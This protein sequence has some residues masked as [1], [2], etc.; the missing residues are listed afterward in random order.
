MHFPKLLVVTEFPPNSPTLMVQCLRGFPPSHIHW[1]SYIPESTR[2]YGQGYA[3]HYRCWIPEILTRPRRYPRVKALVTE[4]LWLPFAARHLQRTV[5]SV[6]PTQLWVNLYGWVAAAAY[7][8]GIIHKAKA[9]ATI[10]DFPDTDEF[11]RRWGKRRCRRV[12]K[13]AQSVYRDATTCDSISEPMRDELQRQTGRQ[14][15][16]ILHSGVEEDEVF[17]LNVESVGPQRIVRIAYAGSILAPTVFQ[18]FM[19][20]LKATSKQLHVEVSIE[21]FGNPSVRQTSWFD[22][23]WMREHGVLEE[24][25]F[26]EHLRQCTWGLL[27]M[28]LHGENPRYNGFSFPNKFG[29]YL[30]AG[31]PILLLSSP[32]SSAAKMLQA[33]AVGVHL[34]HTGLHTH[35]E[36]ILGLDNPRKR[37]LPAINACA[38][39]EFSM[40][41]IRHTLWKNLGVDFTA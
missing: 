38:L 1:W 7:K 21:F 34:D 41:L 8:S 13:W 25:V 4:H 33:H 32:D 11:L 12:L 19:E 22:S 16:C 9:H 23:S 35:L 10:W 29:T 14:D 6:R 28:H 37:F 24:A 17:K 36:E 18:L 31:L 5:E 30:A 15:A 3:H 39:T 26:M 27:A 20:S 2:V 40:P